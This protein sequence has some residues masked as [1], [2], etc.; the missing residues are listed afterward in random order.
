MF[1]YDVTQQD[2][3]RDIPNK[4]VK[5]LREGNEHA[6]LAMVGN[7]IDLPNQTVTI[8]QGKVCYLYTIL[9]VECR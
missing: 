9:I 8:E 2:T 6:V 4:W 5:D 3:L 7:K 1:I